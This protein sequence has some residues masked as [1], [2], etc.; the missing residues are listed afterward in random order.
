M[1]GKNKEVN[2]KKQRNKAANDNGETVGVKGKPSRKGTFDNR[3][4]GG[5]KDGAK[6]KKIGIAVLSSGRNRRQNCRR[7]LRFRDR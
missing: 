5:K 3:E 4:N 1:G 7:K 2:M 6:N